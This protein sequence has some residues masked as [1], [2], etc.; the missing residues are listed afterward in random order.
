MKL[1]LI[2]MMACLSTLA[3]CGSG[4][5]CD[6]PRLYQASQL[7][8]PVQVPEDLDNLQSQKELQIPNVSPRPPRAEDAGCL[9]S[10]PPFT[11]TSN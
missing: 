2:L 9:E 8:E 5:T 10:P 6:E 11:S 4:P 7:S 1:H 3:A